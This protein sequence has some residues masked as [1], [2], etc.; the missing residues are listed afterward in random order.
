MEKQAPREPKEEHET[1]I[2]ALVAMVIIVLGITYVALTWPQD[3]TSEDPAD[4]NTTTQQ[5]ESTPGSLVPQS[6]DERATT[7][8]FNGLPDGI[9]VDESNVSVNEVGEVAAGNQ[10]VVMFETDQPRSALTAEYERYV[11]TSG[12]TIEQNLSDESGAKITANRADE[13]LV[14]ILTSLTESQTRV[15]ITYTN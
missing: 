9:Y 14:V 6:T 10:R 12:F 15:N 3:M 8:S 5:E 1:H 11:E 13:Q 2:T 7:T 4:A